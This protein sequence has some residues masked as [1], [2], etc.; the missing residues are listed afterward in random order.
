MTSLRFLQTT[1]RAKAMNRARIVLVILIASAVFCGLMA[2]ATAQQQ[3]PPGCGPLQPL[4]EVLKQRYGQFRMLELN[5]TDG[6]LVIA[7]S[8]KEGT[9]TV[10]K[11]EGQD[12]A[13]IFA[14]G[15]TS[16]VD[17]GL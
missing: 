7:V 10:L 15:R 16:L 11:V 8:P 17:R 6:K 5:L 4:L 12:A 3:F 14:A 1:M 2:A 9:W 13:C